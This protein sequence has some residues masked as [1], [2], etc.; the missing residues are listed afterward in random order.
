M[1]FL[2]TKK[3]IL[4]LKIKVWD[5]FGIFEVQGQFQYKSEG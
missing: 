2:L 5:N 3:T 4:V 1:V